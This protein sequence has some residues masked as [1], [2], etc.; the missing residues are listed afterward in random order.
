MNKIIKKLKKGFTLIELMVSL[1]IFV[2]VIS[3]SSSILIMTIRSQK[4]AFAQQELLNQTSYLME[5]MS[6]SIR[7]A[8]KDKDGICGSKISNTNYYFS[9]T[10]IEFLNYNGICQK[11]YLNNGE[12]KEKLGA[13]DLPLTSSNLDVEYFNVDVEYG[14]QADNMQPKVTFVLKI[15]SG[16]EPNDANINIQTTISQRNPDVQY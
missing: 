3:S 7:M 15:K 16:V 1:S 14:D 2:L 12:I 11:F 9:P 5:K 4:K 6:K 10:S 13:T 8:R